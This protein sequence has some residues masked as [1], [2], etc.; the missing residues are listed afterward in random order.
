[1]GI[2]VDPARDRVTCE[3]RVV[4]LPVGAQTTTLVLNKPQGYLST[5]S[6][7]QGR[8]TVLDLVPASYH[9]LY[10]VGRLDLDSEGLML[11]TD[12]G[13]L[14]Y[15]L[16][17]PSFEHDK[18]YWVLA[19]GRPPDVVMYKW[20]RGVQ[21]EDG[22][23]K[24]DVRRLVAI[25]PEQR[26]WLDPEPNPG[27]TWFAFVVHEGRK[28]QIRRMCEAVDVRV[29]RLARVRIASIHIGDLRPG[30]WRP[31]SARQQRAVDAIKAAA[32]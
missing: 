16:T 6:D 29:K 32:E 13:D 14:T 12:D 1:M 23:S 27:D 31:L 7:P 11:L 10:P 9:H 15:R 4:E 18:E 5:R 2:V 17:H 26:F 19:A 20:R 3:G 21:L 30:Q 22:V 28:H 25:P 8:P 24:A